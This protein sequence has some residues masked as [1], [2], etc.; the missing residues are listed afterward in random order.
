L[1]FILE[2]NNTPKQTYIKYLLNPCK[3]IAYK[4][5]FLLCVLFVYGCYLFVLFIF[6]PR[7]TLFV[8]KKYVA[9]A[10]KVTVRKKP[11]SGKRHSLY[12]NFHPAVMNSENR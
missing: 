7:R 10:V 6:A 4:G 2:K 1:I 8:P 12:L 3:C 11:I 5:F 9:I